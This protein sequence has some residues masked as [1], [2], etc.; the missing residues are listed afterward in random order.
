MKN[1]AWLRCDVR[2]G[3]FEDEVAICITT[4]D[5]TVISFFI[6]A[7]FVRSFSGTEKAIPV[8]VVDRDSDF[9]VVTLP[10]RSFEG[11]NVA[12]VATRELRFA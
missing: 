9:G 11:S 7:D 3:M 2:P 8:E 6:P 4:A 12:R 1:K 10:R 5:D